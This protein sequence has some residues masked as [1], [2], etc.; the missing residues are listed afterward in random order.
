MLEK[1]DEVS[2]QERR[3]NITIK[4]AKVN[5]KYCV[6]CGVCVKHCPR[7]AISIISGVYARVDEEKCVGCAKCVKSCPASTIYLLEKE[8]RKK[9][10]KD[11]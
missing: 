10:E 3:G 6:A 1:V 5:Q 9:G 8:K 4:R 11:V 2:K 7:K